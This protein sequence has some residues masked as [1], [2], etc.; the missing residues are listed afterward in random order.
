MQLP[1]V[2]PAERHGELV[3]HLHA[4][5]AGLGKPQVVRIAGLPAADQAGLSG[6]EVEVRPV[7]D[8]FGL[9]KRQR[10]FVDPPG[11]QIGRRRRK[12]RGGGLFRLPPLAIEVLADG[13]RLP[14]AIVPRGPRDGR[15]VVRMK[16]GPA[17]HPC[18][19]HAR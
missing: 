8:P 14:L 12:R 16:A 3:A 5:G 19:R 2:S 15:R 7:A 6:D 9:G 18:R 10:A 11:R 17:R 13:R 4:D 1:V